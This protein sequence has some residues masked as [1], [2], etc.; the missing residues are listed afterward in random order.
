MN[1]TILQMTKEELRRDMNN[2]D[3]PSYYTKQCKDVYY[4]KYKVKGL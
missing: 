4:N 1:K 3:L 2:K